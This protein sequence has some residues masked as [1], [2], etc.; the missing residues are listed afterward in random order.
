MRSRTSLVLST[1]PISV[2]E[3]SMSFPHA[4]RLGILTLVSA[5][6]LCV[7]TPLR[8]QDDHALASLLLD[9]LSDL[10]YIKRPTRQHA[11]DVLF[12]ISRTLSQDGAA[13]CTAGIE[14]GDR[15]Q[16]TTFPLPS[17]S[18]GF[19]YTTDPATGEIRLAAA[20]FGPV[21]AERALTIGKRRFDFGLAFQPT[22]FDSF[23]TAELS[24]GSMQFILEHNNCCPGSAAGSTDVA[25]RADRR[26]D[27]TLSTP[28]SSAICCSLRFPS[29][30]RRIPRCSSRITAS[31]IV[32]M[33]A[34]PFPSSACRSAEASRPRSFAPPRADNPWH[35]QL[36][37]GQDCDADGRRNTFRHRPGRRTAAREV[38]LRAA[39]TA[40]RSPP[41]SIFACRRATKTTCWEPARRRP[42]FSSL[43]PASTAFSPL[44][45]A[46]V[47]RS[48]T[49]KSAISRRM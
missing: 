11:C 4:R 17:S 34:P 2:E 32:S 9:L 21:Y 10:V 44:T 42:R 15:T 46:L 30:S 28:S 24:D 20:T 18:G 45:R 40:M 36:R 35:P 14:Q 23:E 1:T 8:A 48:P 29:T 22:S 12:R 6:L 19:A 5:A 3:R 7:A 39:A 27:R 43:R 41:R 37:R 49:A 31:Q 13:T 16:L 26:Q 33:S 38:Q 47:T 25:D